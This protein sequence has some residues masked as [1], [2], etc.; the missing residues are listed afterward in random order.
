MTDTPL[1]LDALQAAAEAATPGPWWDRSD[2]Y[3]Q[4]AP[5]YGEYGW[6]VPGC[7]A[8]ETEDSPQG[9]ADA[10]YIA[11][12]DPTT[13]LALIRRVR[14]AEAERDKCAAA[15]VAAYDGN[16]LIQ[17]ANAAR[18][19]AEATLAKVRHY[20]EHDLHHQSAGRVYEDLTGLL[21][22]A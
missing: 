2:E 7:P 11:A 8:G 6:S 18:D 20:L 12:A 13:I 19:E 17:Q 1:D 4:S 14:D 9:R 10:A 5:H 21:G 22:E 16:A 3:G 15:A